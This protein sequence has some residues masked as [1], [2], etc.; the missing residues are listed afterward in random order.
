MLIG[1]DTRIGIIGAEGRMGSFL[2]SLSREKGLEVLLADKG[3]GDVASLARSSD[4]IILA[5]PF[6]AMDELLRSIGGLIRPEALLMDIT[7]IKIRPLKLMLKTT[8]CNVVGAHPLFGP[9][10]FDEDG[11]GVIL[12]PG[13][14]ND[15]LKMAR[16]FWETLGLQVHLSSAEEH[17]RIMGI[18][19]G[20]FHGIAFSM[21]DC[22]ANMCSLERKKL[23]EQSTFNFLIML[24]RI[25]ALVFQPS[26]LYETI[27]FEN[28]F[29]IDSIE[30]FIR[31]LNELRDWI[32]KDDRESFRSE[33]NK[34]KEVLGHETS[35]GQD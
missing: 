17:D 19:Q 31:S 30:A 1:P 24:K 35:L 29:A 8:S 12:C 25:K 32:K 34:I 13:R 6:Y 16:A 7:S 28:P 21:A 2:V 23:R 27:F 10:S 11:L 22:L 3:V 33:I 14:G 5:I 20:V 18:V 9:E 4:L 26:F 15:S